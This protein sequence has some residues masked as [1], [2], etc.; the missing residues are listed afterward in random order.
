MTHT[1]TILLVEDETI[2]ALDLESFLTDLGWTVITRATADQASQ[3][4]RD[5]RLDAVILDHGLPGG[6]AEALAD[7]LLEAGIR[8]V[9]CTGRDRQEIAA[10][11]SHV[12]LVGKPFRDDEIVTALEGL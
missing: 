3:V 8:L 12:S 9:F 1:K 5:H 2:I 10:R 4:A 7:Q 6:G 11:F